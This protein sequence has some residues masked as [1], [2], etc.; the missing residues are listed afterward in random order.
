MQLELEKYR[1]Q[2]STTYT[3]RFAGEKARSEL[4]LNS[5]DKTEEKIELIIPAG[6]T[7]INP[8]F[9]LGLLYDSYKKFKSKDAFLRKYSFR[10]L[11]DDPFIKEILQEN[12]ED[13]LREAELAFSGLSGFDQFIK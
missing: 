3:G 8:S 5:I 10:F 1:G 7:S 12:I 11:D 6:T 9:F 13:A 2:N 4:K